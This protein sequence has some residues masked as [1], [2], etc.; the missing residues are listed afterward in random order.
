MKGKPWPAEK[1]QK[2]R[3]LAAA[4]ADVDKIAAFLG[5]SRDAILKK[6]NRLGL[7]V[8]GAKG[9]ATTTSIPLP[10]DL[11]SVEEALIILAGA[12]KAACDSG[13]DRVEVQRL[14]VVATLAR[15]YKDLLADYINYRA[16]EAK[17]IDLEA[18]YATLLRE[19]AEGD[20]AK[21][22]PASVVSPARK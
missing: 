16:I 2:L 4:G 21:P 15:T 13:L 9:H 1:E 17:L 18:K 7:E 10:K 22:D 11:P 8:I 20:A 6:A 5:K 19:K 12:L 14:H 3:E